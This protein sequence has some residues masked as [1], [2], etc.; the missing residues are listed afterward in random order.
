MWVVIAARNPPSGRETLP[1]REVVHPHLGTTLWMPVDGGGEGSCT[2]RGQPVS[3]PGTDGGGRAPSTAGPSCPPPH[4][5]RCPQA[6]APADQRGRAPS[7]QSTGV[8]TTAVDLFLLNFE[9]EQ[10]RGWIRGSPI[11]AVA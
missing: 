7:P 11:G 8:S 9:E 6:A 10:R 4:P 5:P 3:N 2:D 1:Q